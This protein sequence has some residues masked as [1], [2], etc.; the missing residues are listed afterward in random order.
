[1]NDEQ[2]EEYEVLL[3]IF[4]DELKKLGYA[5]FVLPPEY[6]SDLP[7]VF[8]N[9]GFDSTQLEA[10]LIEMA[11]Q[12]RGMVMLFTLI[13]HINSVVEERNEIDR[14]EAERMEQLSLEP[15]LKGLA[16]A[17]KKNGTPVTAET[18]AKWKAA[19]DKERMESKEEME[20]IRRMK[21][22]LTGRQMFEK[23]KTL[24]ASDVNNGDDQDV[25]KVIKLAEQGILDPS[26]FVHDENL[27]LDFSE[28]ENED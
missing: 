25:G 11:E 10:E 12:N 17:E 24:I 9:V 14:L 3:S 23:D 1:M 8:L 28:D 22:K 15:E 27:P 16:D 2:T 7:E 18:F 13:S 6:P 21:G 5:E 26:L 19:F 20:R 4:P